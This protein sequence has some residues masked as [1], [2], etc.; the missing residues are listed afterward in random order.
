M[1]KFD[2]QRSW[3]AVEER[4]REETN[5]RHKAMLTV[6]R[7]HLDH[8]I[9][10]RLDE[11]MGTLCAHPTHH[12][13]GNNPM[14]INGAAGLRAFYE[15]MITGGSNQF[16]VVVEKVIVDDENVVTEGQ[17]NTVYRGGD[18]AA[19]DMTEINGEPIDPEGLYLTSTQLITVWPIDDDCLLQGEDIYLAG[20]PF[21]ACVKITA[22][23]V[24]QGFGAG[25]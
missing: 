5:S 3:I 8:E 25:K 6:V 10:G 21:D 7:D 17:L 15:A 20:N 19:M 24:P 12:I 18:M 4:A 16:E 9:S 23:D 1:T 22:A 13:Y 11:L 2:P 14:T